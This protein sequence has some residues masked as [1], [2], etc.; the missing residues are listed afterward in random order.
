M[1]PKKESKKIDVAKGFEELEE[2]AAWFEK[3]DGGLDEGLKRFERAMTL[4]GALKTRLDEA[5]NV[6]R[7]IKKRF[8]VADE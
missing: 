7:E 5:E 6:I 2:I 3:G 1:T 4:A 8:D